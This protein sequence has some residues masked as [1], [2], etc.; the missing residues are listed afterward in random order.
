MRRAVAAVMLLSTLCLASPAA[1]ASE[2]Q[3]AV[4][5]NGAAS[6]W[7]SDGAFAGTLHV[8]FRFIDLVGVYFL[9]RIGY[10]IVDD[11]MLESLSFGAKIWGRLGIV[12]PYARLG[13]LHIHEEPWA[14]V[15]NQPGGAILGVG[16]GIRHRTGLEA[17]LG[18]DIP[19]YKKERWQLVV[20]A[21]ATTDWVTFSSGPSWYWGGG[22]SIGFNYSL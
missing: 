13:V 16:D 11:R 12:R 20:G 2:L 3:I 15:K 17:G 22:L 4:G 9:G 6:D 8:G 7:R 19:V 18:I 21:E 10:G 1:R 14:A 5:L